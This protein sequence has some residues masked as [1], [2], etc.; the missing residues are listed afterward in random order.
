MKQ[1]LTTGS[2]KWLV[3][4]KPPEDA[5]EWSMQK[6]WTVMPAEALQDKK[7]SLAIQLVR[8]LDSRLSQVA[9]PSCQFTLLWKNWLFTFLS[10]S[11]INTL[12]THKILR[13]SRENFKREKQDWLIHNL[14]IVTL[15]IPQLSPSPFVTSLRGSLGKTFLTIPISVRR[16]FGALGSNLEGTNSY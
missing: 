12:Y 8:G 9:R 6:S 5:H 7:S 11:S 14:Y 2:H 15:Q 4:C 3:T 16:I 1:G 10:H 13:G